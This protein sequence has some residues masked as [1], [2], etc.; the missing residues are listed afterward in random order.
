MNTDAILG[1]VAK[2]IGQTTTQ[3]T[4]RYDQLC[5]LSAYVAALDHL[6]QGK[7]RNALVEG[8]WSKTY[9]KEF[10]EACIKTLRLQAPSTKAIVTDRPHS[11]PYDIDGGRLVLLSERAYDDGAVE[12]KAVPVADFYASITEEGTTEEGRKIYT[13]AGETVRSGKF[14]VDIDAEEFS[15]DRKLK[16]ALEAAAGARD[17]VRAGMGKH[18]GPAIKL[19]TN[20]DL[21]HTQRYLRTG[22]QGDKF[23]IPGREAQDVTIRLPRKLPYRIDPAAELVKGLECLDLLIRFMG[24]QVGTVVMSHLF[25]APLAALAGWRNE[26]T[27]VFIRGRTGTHKSSAA[28]VAMCLYGPDFMEDDRLIKWGEGATRNAI[29]SYS[30]SAHDLPFLV[31]NYKPSTGGGA[32]D[33]TNLIHNIMEGGDKERL[34]RAATL[35]ET[36]PIHTWPF[37][38]GEDVPNNDPASIARILITPFEQGRDTELLTQAQAL[39]PH[40]CAVGAVWFDFLESE[41]GRKVATEIGGELNSTR[42]DW[43]GHIRAKDSKTINP[44]RVATNLATNFLAWSA[45]EQCPALSEIAQRYAAD[46]ADGLQALMGDMAKLTTQSLEANRLLDALRETIASGRGILIRDRAIH[47]NTLQDQR[48]RD[49]VIGWEDGAG[50]YLLPDIAIALLERATGL[51]LGGV[52]KQTLYDQMDEMGVIAKKGKDRT[53]TVMKCGGKPERVLHLKLEALQP[54]DDSQPSES[55]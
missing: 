22:W 48:D 30:T 20:G 41:D 47:P 13:V 52:S 5:E 21:R 43:Y 2:I 27:G 37:F 33:F 11:W 44:M 25:L 32:H 6:G 23:L 26:R 53:T 10:L 55:E 49:R 45:V 9:A 50:V 51:D 19:M 40:L 29:M 42:M 16:A 3:G 15:D 38:T 46:H 54:H 36:K 12:V 31:D 39:A 14:A 8:G 1:E 4:E 34:T 17:P 35:R 18:L 28:Q 24:P 7:V